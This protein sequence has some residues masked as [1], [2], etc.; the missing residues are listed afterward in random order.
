MSHIRVATITVALLASVFFA[1]HDAHAFGRRKAE[2]LTDTYTAQI[3]GGDYAAA[4]AT[5]E[6]MLSGRAL[7]KQDK[8]EVDGRA[9]L[10]YLHM[11]SASAWSGDTDA[12]L[13]QLD[14]AEAAVK[15]Y[16]TRI[17]GAGG[18]EA[19]AATLVGNAAKKYR[20]K[21]YEGILINAY[22]AVAFLQ[23]SRHDDARVELHRAD[24][25]IRRAVEVFAKEI[26]KGQQAI[27]DKNPG[28]NAASDQESGS[29]LAAH[30]GDL[31]TWQVYDD[32]INPYAA[33]IH[34]L[35]FFAQGDSTSDI[36]TAVTSIERVAG[37]Y[38]GNAVLVRD[39]EVVTGVASG[40][41]TRDTLPDYVWVICED[42]IG[43]SYAAKEIDVAL[44]IDKQ[45]VPV[46][47]VLP[48]LQF[49]DHGHGGCAVD[50]A[51]TLHSAEEIGSMDRVAQTEFKKRL[52]REISQS[53]AGLIV[54]TLLQNELQ[55]QGGL[56][57][58]LVG[59]AYQKA[60]A[61]TETRGWRGLPKVWYAVR[62]ERPADGRLV[63]TDP[64]G[65]ALATVEVPDVRA[66]LVHVRTPSRTARV[67][68]SV[69]ALSRS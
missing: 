34:G 18:A 43:P 27:E 22:K 44:P 35:F 65:V 13:R 3:S 58:A 1:T 48:E 59:L 5:A 36:E 16:E 20:P 62:V 26:E 2:E 54:R 4:A 39:L 51:G 61:T 40:T 69:A 66:A 31:D 52:P 45:A 11:G 63:V 42:G 38:P 49:H 32:F 56:A 33:Y 68:T 21:Q 15:D 57:G 24:E 37:M 23:T 41:T 9:L 29:I 28:A 30:Y 60:T 17:L 47:L 53:I 46:R 14:Q 10:A 19:V 50:L 64:R 7:R 67:A 8:G 6:K 55:K 25:R 12:A